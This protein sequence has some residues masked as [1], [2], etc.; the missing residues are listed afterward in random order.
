MSFKEN[1]K[2]KIKIEKLLHSLVSTI[3]EPP[4]RRW[5]DKVLAQELFDMTDFEHLILFDEENVT[6][7]L[8][9][10]IFSARDDSLLERVMQYAR[11]EERADLQGIDVFEF[12]A[13]LALEKA[14]TQR[15]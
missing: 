1:L 12:L 4:G 13:E 5:L 6:L 8:K 3:K 2:A 14:E 11:G 9:K 7:S 10:G 15:Q